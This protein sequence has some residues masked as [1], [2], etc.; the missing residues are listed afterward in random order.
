[1]VRRSPSPNCPPTGRAVGVRQ[2]HAVVVGVWVWGPNTGDKIL[3]DKLDPG[4]P[5]GRLYKVRWKGV[6]SVRRFLE[7]SQQLCSEVHHGLDGL[8]KEEGYFLGCQGG[9]GPFSGCNS[10]LMGPL[11]IYICFLMS[12]RRS[13]GV[14]RET[15]GLYWL[16]TPFT[17]FPDIYIHCGTCIQT[18]GRRFVHFVTPLVH[19]VDQGKTEYGGGYLFWVTSPLSWGTPTPYVGTPCVLG[20]RGGGLDSIGVLPSTSDRCYNA[21]RRGLKPVWTP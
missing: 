16:Y 19:V 12:G 21:L 15:F 10:P 18:G 3:T 2:P 13:E 8:C 4:T 5:E 6:C 20:T 14:H 9:F 11:G 17:R 7:A 1:M